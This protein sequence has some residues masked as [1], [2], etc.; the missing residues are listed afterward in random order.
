MVWHYGMLLFEWVWKVE[1]WVGWHWEREVMSPVCTGY[2]LLTIWLMM[3][4][5]LMLTIWL[6]MTITC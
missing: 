3:T 5:W 4:I 2:Y 1:C 6:M